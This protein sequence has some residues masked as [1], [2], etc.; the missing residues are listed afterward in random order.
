MRLY[1]G[2]ERFLRQADALCQKALS[3]SDCPA[4]VC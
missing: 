4:T 1:D 2:R 3:G